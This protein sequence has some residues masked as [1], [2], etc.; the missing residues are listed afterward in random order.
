MSLIYTLTTPIT[1]G[2]LTS[3][4]TVSSLKLTSISLNFEDAYTQDGIAVL[5]IC[6]ADPVSGYPVNV[7]YQDASALSMAQTIEAQ[8][9]AE[10]FQKLIVDGKLPAGTLADTVATTTTTPA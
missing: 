7:V 8:I 9:G 10:L 4:L 1:I 5:S 6:L 2:D 3:S